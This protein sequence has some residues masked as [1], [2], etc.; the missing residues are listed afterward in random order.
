MLKIKYYI[1]NCSSLENWGF[2]D[3]E[4]CQKAT[5]FFVIPMGP[6]TQLWIT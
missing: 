6:L 3:S 2:R 1:V 5:G 4:H